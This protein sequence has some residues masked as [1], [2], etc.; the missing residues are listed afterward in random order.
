VEWHIGINGC[1]KI[2]ILTPSLPNY[3]TLLQLGSEIKRLER[4]F[5][6]RTER[7]MKEYFDWK[8]QH[9]A[10]NEKIIGGTNESS[11]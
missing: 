7:E 6:E 9:E 1:T 11:E 4:E 10:K 5:K 3:P 2:K 8:A